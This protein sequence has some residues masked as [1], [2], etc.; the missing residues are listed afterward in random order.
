MS[1]RSGSLS[2]GRITSRIPAR[3]APSTFS[4]TPPMGRTLPVRVISPVM[5]MSCRTG[6]SVRAETK[7]LTRATPAEGPSLGMA[8][9]GTWMWMSDLSNFSRGMPKRRAFF[10]A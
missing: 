8:P 1:E 5:A 7:A 9:A 3:L 10:L 2:L 4:F 6:T